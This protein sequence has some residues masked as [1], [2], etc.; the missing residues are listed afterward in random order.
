M[1]DADDPAHDA[2]LELLGSHPGPLFVPTLCVAEIAQLAASRLGARPEARFLNDLYRGL[3]SVMA[4]QPGEWARIAELVW[5]YRE[6]RLGTVDA[7]VVALAERLR[8]TQIATL[9]R[10]HFSIVKPLHVETFE[11]LP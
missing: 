3:F 6:L 2:C 1:L 4:V 5:G 7:S 8:V 10:K 9:D 11:L